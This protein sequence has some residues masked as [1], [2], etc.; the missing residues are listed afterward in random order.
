MCHLHLLQVCINL[1][2][3]A[4]TA[5]AY[6]ATGMMCMKLF[7]VCYV[8]QHPPKYLNTIKNSFWYK[9]I[10]AAVVVH[11]VPQLRQIL[12]EGSLIALLHLLISQILLY[13]LFIL[14]VY[15]ETDINKKAHDYKT[16]T[17]NVH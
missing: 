8:H 3:A 12:T 1:G 11:A 17:E 16:G 9:S 15:K 14:P 10:L 4:G 5:G 6:F 2:V 13:A 7:V